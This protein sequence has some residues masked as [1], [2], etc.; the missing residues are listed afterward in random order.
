MDPKDMSL[1][2]LIKKDPAMKRRG[3]P[4]KKG[5]KPGGGVPRAKTGPFKNK[6]QQQTWAERRP[7]GMGKVSFPLT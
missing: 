4:F 5:D 6:P 3:K 1:D 2:Q 7:V